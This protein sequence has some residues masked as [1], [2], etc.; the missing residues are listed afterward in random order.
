MTRRSAIGYRWATSALLC[1]LLLGG[2]SSSTDRPQAPDDTPV[3]IALPEATPGELVTLSFGEVTVTG[4]LLYWASA[5]APGD[6]IFWLMPTSPA[7]P[8][9]YGPLDPTD[10]GSSLEAFD[11]KNAEIL[12][13]NEAE[14][15]E[16][17]VCIA[18]DPTAVC[19]RVEVP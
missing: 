18:P 11:R 17:L 16:A 9:E 5:S 8:A 15:G 12:V 19:I 13:P 14:P 7:A 2:C 3:P 4:S 10:I 6:F 1:G